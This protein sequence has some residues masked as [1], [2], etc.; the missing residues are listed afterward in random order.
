MNLPNFI[1]E[2][3]FKDRV[4]GNWP[5]VGKPVTDCAE[6]SF[7]KKCCDPNAPLRLAG[8]VENNIGCYGGWKF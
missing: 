8:K 2:K 5:K 3:A 4:K 1:L 7:Y 6:C